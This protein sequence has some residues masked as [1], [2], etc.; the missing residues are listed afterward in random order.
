MGGDVGELL[1]HQEGRDLRVSALRAAGFTLIELLVALTIAAILL[2]LAAPLYTTWVADNQISNGAQLVADGLRTAQGEAIKRNAQVQL[3]LNSTTGT[4]GWTVQTECDGTV[5]QRGYFSQ[6]ADKVAFAVTPAGST[7]VTFTGLGQ[8]AALKC[9]GTALPAPF[10]DVD[11][12]SAL[13]GTRALR[14]TVGGGRTGIKLCDPNLTT[15]DPQAC[16]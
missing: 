13:S 8:V 5:L 2:V 1:G 15:P 6:G 7:T 10:T 4:G 12:T 9:D 16:P 14:V 11:V 3:V